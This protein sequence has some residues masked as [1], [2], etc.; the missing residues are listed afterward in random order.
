MMQEPKIA[1]LFNP[2]VMNFFQTSVIPPLAF[3]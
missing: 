2:P 1:A 3:V